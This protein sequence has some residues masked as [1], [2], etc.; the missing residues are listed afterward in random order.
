MISFLQ[1]TKGELHFRYRCGN[2]SPNTLL[3]R[4]D[5][6][7]DGRWHDVLLEVN[8]TFLRLTLD[9]QH[10]AS[11]SLTEPCRMLRSHGAL[12]FAPLLK[13]SVREFGR[14]AHHFMG[15]LEGLKLNGEPIS[16]A[17]W[18][19][20]GSRRVFGVFQCCSRSGGCDSQS[21]ENGGVCREDEAGGEGTSQTF[22]IQ[23]LF[24]SSKETVAV[25]NRTHGLLK[26]TY[27]GSIN[28]DT[29]PQS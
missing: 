9:Q 21:C 5:P 15:C 12:L 16:A 22:L 18:M 6:V 28:M 24:M 27:T 3:I 17:E 13:N 20:S 25:S 29:K 7:S 10:P 4:S 11:I 19:G 8:T 1:L 26:F 23:T 2:T 14:D